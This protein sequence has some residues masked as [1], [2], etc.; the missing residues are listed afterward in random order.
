M[1]T[2]GDKMPVSIHET[3]PGFTSHNVSIEKGDAIY[4]FSDGYPDQFGGPR[5]KKFMYKAFKKLLCDVSGRSMLEQADILEK[6]MMDWQGIL[7]QID[8]MVI[9]GLR[10]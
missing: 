8:D 9:I 6:T 2:K 5:G 10:V 4:L 3:M 1:E 7:D